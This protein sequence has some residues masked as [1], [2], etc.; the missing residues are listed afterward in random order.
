M[1]VVVKKVESW[2]RR[3]WVAG[4]GHRDVMQLVAL[5]H[6]VHIP[7]DETEGELGAEV[8]KRS[9]VWLYEAQEVFAW[10]IAQGS[11]RTDV[12]AI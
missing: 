2:T 11:S 4:P 8:E 10:S 6:Q 5:D 7:H 9:P 12:W 3:H 1:G